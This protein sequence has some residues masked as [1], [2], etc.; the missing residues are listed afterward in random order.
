MFAAS[1]I[2]ASGGSFQSKMKKGRV[3]PIQVWQFT[4]GQAKVPEIEYIALLRN[5]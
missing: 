4:F 1:P 5:R 3:C 2:G